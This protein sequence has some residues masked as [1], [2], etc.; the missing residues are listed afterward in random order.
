LPQDKKAAIHLS[1]GRSIWKKLQQHANAA[2]VL[3]SSVFLIVEQMNHGLE[4][5]ADETEMVSAS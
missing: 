5:V 3:E 1:I 2:Q 4:L